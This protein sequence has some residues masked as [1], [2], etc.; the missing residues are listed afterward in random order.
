MIDQW[1]EAYAPELTRFIRSKGLTP[2]DAEDVCSQVFLE[3][4]R[5]Q[6]A[7]IAPRAWLYLVAKNRIIER[8][9]RDGKMQSVTLEDWHDPSVEMPEIQEPL[10]LNCLTTEQKAVIH[11]RFTEDRTVE[12]TAALLGIKPAAV[13]G[14]QHRALDR[15]RAERKVPPPNDLRMPVPTTPPAVPDPICANGDGALAFLRLN[16]RALCAACALLWLD[17]K[18]APAVHDPLC[19]TCAAVGYVR[20]R[21][22]VLCAACAL[23]LPFSAL[24][25]PVKVAPR[26]KFRHWPANQPPV[27]ATP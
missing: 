14:R 3:A 24:A 13:R 23:N 10:P 26:G 2:E 4:V 8:W 22:M 16:R 6:P 19:M 5:A 11:A 20:M 18:P 1:Y 17:P 27:W 21:G 7:D 9:R 25:A 12:E 15:L